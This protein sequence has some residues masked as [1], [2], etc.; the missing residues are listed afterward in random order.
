MKLVN[1]LIPATGS[2]RGYAI[3]R[4]F[5]ATPVNVNFSAMQLDGIPFRPSG[6]F[7]DNSQGASALI[8]VINELAMRI[9]CPAGASLQTQFP[10]PMSMTVTLVGDGQASVNFV[11]FPVIPF[12]SGV[13]SGGGGGAVTI[14]NGASVALGSTTDVPV[15]DPDSA[16]S[17]VALLKG[18]L[19]VMQ[20]QEGLD[21]TGNYLPLGFGNSGRAFTYD[22]NGNVLTETAFHGADEYIRTYVY[23]GTTLDNYSPWVKQ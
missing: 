11:D 5:D 18:T 10:A 12:L 23:T 13:S 22:G 19:E 2:T 20:A 4:V 8:I 9:T 3:S 17:V 16:A 15:F 1:Y 6:V 14:A 7:I 21:S